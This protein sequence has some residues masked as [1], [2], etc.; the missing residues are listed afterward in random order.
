MRVMMLGLN[1]EQA[2]LD[3]RE[4]VALNSAHVPALYS[5]LKQLAGY[6]GAVILSTCNRTE[7]YTTDALSMVDVRRCWSEQVGVPVRDFA[8]ALYLRVGDDAIFHLF[9][10]TAGLDAMVLGE[11]EILGQ[12][13]AAYAAAQQCHAVGSL[14]RTFQAAIKAAKRAHTET[15]ISER[16]LSLGYAAVELA[17][18]VFGEG[19]PGRRVVV[20]GAGEMGAN[21]LRHMAD[22]GVRHLVIVNRTPERAEPL[23]REVGA[24]LARWE[25]LPK[26][27]AA[28]DVVITA[29]KSPMPV[30]LAPWVA[31]QVRAR[32][33]DP[34]LFLD[35]SVPRNVPVG[36][37][38]LSGVLRYDLDDLKA[39]VQRNRARRAQEVEAVRRILSEEQESLARDA[40]AAEVAP[41][42][43]SLRRKAERIRQAELEEL[44]RRHPNWSESE[45]SA[46]ERA[47]HLMM[48]K[49][50]ND[51]MVSI[52]TWAS[53]PDGTVYVNTLRELFRLDDEP[54]AP[55]SD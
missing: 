7:I 23:V 20:V 26:E 15:A 42:I 25:D 39:V 14:H 40:D 22:A 41:V 31:D 21:A 52:R 50:L 13:K 37:G 43:R 35:L 4:R 32:R 48:T 46:V 44:W 55:A 1:H 10:V 19:L 16:A 47:T 24:R 51:P 38:R 9:R 6:E 28:S 34:W 3:L 33:G 36:V 2:G 18:Q 29:T 54:L 8:D 12:V 27:V 17:R 49:L 11:T 5:A 30:V 53:L 45:R